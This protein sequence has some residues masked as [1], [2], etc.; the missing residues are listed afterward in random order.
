MRRSA[1][2]LPL[3]IALSVIAGL[4]MSRRFNRG[5]G[6]G[7]GAGSA[8]LM[9]LMRYIDQSYVDRVD[10]DSLLGATIDAML[11]QLD[12]HSSYIDAAYFSQ[13]EEN[14]HGSFY[15]IGVEFNIIRDTVVVVT[16]ISGGPSEQLG[17]RSG[18]RIVEVEGDT[19][20]G[21]GMQNNDI[22]NLLRG[23]RGTEVRVG[24]VRPG[25]DEILPF[26]IIRDEIPIHSLDA[27]YLINDSVGYIKLNRFAE[28]TMGEYLEGFDKLK[29]SSDNL[30]G[31]ILDLRGNPGGFLH[32]A[33][34][35]ADEF[36][37]EG[38]DIVHTEGRMRA[39]KNNV[40][41]RKGRWEQGGLAILI[42]GGSAS[43]S[44]IVAG[45][46][47]DHDRGW[48]LGN[49]SFGK[50]LVQEQLKLSD[51]SAV[52][53]TVARYYTPSGRCIQRPYT[54]SFAENDT[55]KIDTFYTDMGRPVFDGGGIKP[56]VE[57]A[58]DSTLYIRSY[59][60]LM[61]HGDFRNF[62]FREADRIRTGTTLN[63][64]SVWAAWNAPDVRAALLGRFRKHVEG[65]GFSW[66]DR[67]EVEVSELI[68]NQL[69]AL[70]ARQIWGD[71]TFYRMLN[72]DDAYIRTALDLIFKPVHQ[73]EES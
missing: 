18:D 11:Q 7:A 59:Y 71:E 3:I 68:V 55:A 20:A 17:I 70:I 51:G 69:Q 65:R 67:L 35:L 50:G 4:Y 8:K 26:T 34:S 40:A 43:A 10:A 28:N 45:A 15:G 25:V 31:L 63:P 53:L 21:T 6:Y 66:P 27:A 12:P 13:V 5:G 60:F 22:I 72:R 73:P 48:I 57:V 62:A 19:I 32:I 23:E 9:E 29:R 36:L 14:L 46:V 44:E 37:S 2:Y 30:K 42:D 41:T 16:A 58:E 52:R 64:D 1:I 39:N 38:Q 49:R 24:I 33:T 61:N 47:Q 54:D 56:D